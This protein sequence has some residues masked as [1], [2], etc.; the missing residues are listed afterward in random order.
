MA[1][2]AFKI[3]CDVGE[4]TRAMDAGSNAAKKCLNE[5]LEAA[6]DEIILGI[7]N[8]E[9]RWFDHPTG[10]LTKELWRGTATAGAIEGGWSGASAVYGPSLE[11]GPTD[12]GPKKVYPKGTNVET[13]K[14]LKAL[15][16]MKGESVVYRKWSTYQWKDS[17]KRPHWKKALKLQSV[18]SKIKAIVSA[19]VTEGFRRGR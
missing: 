17:Q 14:P 10:T 6:M 13:G 1:L 5:V 16:W 8:N 19:R 4:L 9:K 18:R 11:W 7:R 3:K 12:K 2:G 15:R